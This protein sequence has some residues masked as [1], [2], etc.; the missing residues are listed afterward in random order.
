[1][2]GIYGS[3]CFDNFK[4]LYAL[5]INRGN[6][7]NG[8][9]FI[10]N[11][12]KSIHISRNEGVKQYTSHPEYDVDMYLG[13]T[14]SP[15]GSVR[16]FHPS[17]TH[18]FETDHWLVAHNG[19]INNYKELIQNHLPEHRCDVDSSVIPGI[20]ELHYTH[21]HTVSEIDFMVKSCLDN[22]KGTYGIFLYNKKYNILYVARCGST[23]YM[24]ESKTCFSSTQH[25]GFSELPELT[26]Y[27]SHP[28]AGN[29]NKFQKIHQLKNNS[30][31]IIF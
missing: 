10:S 29:E 23:L 18:P 6:F 25:D 21:S 4:E 16:D 27:R 30:S 9:V 17:T 28:G 13:H 22:I 8:H 7:A 15:T 3:V 19:V 1:M 24:N 11:K 26:L 2:C 14:Q 31:F 12:D 5:N 20:L